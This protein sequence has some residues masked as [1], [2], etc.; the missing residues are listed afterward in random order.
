[1]TLKIYMKGKYEEGKRGAQKRSGFR[2][3]ETEKRRDLADCGRRTSV[4]IS[5]VLNDQL[6]CQR[7]TEQKLFGGLSTKMLLRK[8]L[9][10][11][12]KE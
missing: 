7:K 4:N 2:R 10:G 1:V 6:T 9:C 5:R 8:Q 11:G 12:S 3:R